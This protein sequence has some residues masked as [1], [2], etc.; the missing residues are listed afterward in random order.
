MKIQLR[1]VETREFISSTHFTFTA[2]F[3]LRCLYC[4][5]YSLA[6][7]RTLV[8]ILGH[9]FLEPQMHT[10]MHI[11]DLSSDCIVLTQALATLFEL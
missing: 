5:C 9:L 10:Q 2:I 1:L 11:Q 4:G 3:M 6:K 8:L 7:F